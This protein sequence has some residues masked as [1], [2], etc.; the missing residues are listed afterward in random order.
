MNDIA[1]N[2]KSLRKEKG[3][4]QEQFAQK[5]H[6]TRQMVSAWER[7]LSRPGLETIRQ[8]AQMLEVGEEQVLYGPEAGKKPVKYR[9]VSYWPVLLVLP[10]WYFGVYI[11]GGILQMFLGGGTGDSLIVIAG[12]ILLGMLIVFC[13]CCLKDEIRNRD[14]YERTTPEEEERQDP[15]A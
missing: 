6:V 9:S 5:L 13:Y 7:G 1:A 2:I 10:G 15:K 12:Q 4:S 8:I 14:Y 3:L 11:I